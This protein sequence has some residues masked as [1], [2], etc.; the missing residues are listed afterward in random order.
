MVY[1]PTAFSVGR[2]DEDNVTAVKKTAK[3]LREL[4]HHV[5]EVDFSHVDGEEFLYQYVLI[6]CADTA[7]ML[8]AAS[9]T[10]GKKVT[11]ADVEPRTWS[12]ALIGQRLSADQ[13]IGAHWYF[14]QFSRDWLTRYD[15]YDAII[16]STMAQAP[17]LIG[18]HSKLP[19]EDMQHATTRLLPFLAKLGSRRDMILKTFSSVIEYM[20]QTMAA[21]VTG[22]PAISLPMHMNA[23]GLPIGVMATGRYGDE[24]TLLQLAQQLEM[25]VQWH[26][27]R[28]AIA[29]AN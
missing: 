21:N 28:P 17:A 6:L 12:L 29:T 13:V 20:P 7:A 5:H 10:L 19:N 11:A 23:A 25:R 27:L 8:K 1:R 4:G 16:T 24:A 2:L 22:Q 3:L 9:K 18:Q 14:Q 26:K 15:C